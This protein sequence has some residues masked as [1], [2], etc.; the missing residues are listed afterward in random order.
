MRARRCSAPR[1]TPGPTWCRPRGAP[2]RTVEGKGTLKEVRVKDFLTTVVLAT[3][4]SR[5]SD[6]AARA[7][8]DLCERTGARLHVVHVW[9]RTPAA[10]PTPVAALRFGLPEEEAAGVLEGQVKR[11]EAG[12]GAVE[13]AHL[14]RGLAAGES[15]P[16]PGS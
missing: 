9:Q 13:E 1:V 15:P 16:L 3:D 7:A 12:G 11:I 6:L 4:G 10:F 8:V 14:R 5:G 2:A